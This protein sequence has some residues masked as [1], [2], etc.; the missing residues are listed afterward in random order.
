MVNMKRKL[1]KQGGSA[2]TITLPFK[3]TKQFGLEAGDELDVEEKENKLIVSTFSDI[4]GEKKDIDLTEQSSMIKRIL[5]SLYK[6]GYDE[7]HVQFDNLQQFELAQEVVREEFIGFEIVEQRKKSITVK[8]ISK[9]EYSEFDTMLRRMFMII[10]LMGEESLEAAK[11]KDKEQLK[12]IT[13]R[14][15]DVNKIADY[16]RRIINKKGLML[17][18]RPAPLYYIVEELEKIGDFYRDLCRHFENNG[19]DKDIEALYGD[20]NSFYSD[21]YDMFLKFDLKS[22]DTFGKKRET[23]KK[24]VDSLW[25]KTSVDKHALHYLGGLLNSLFD[26]NGPL[27]AVKL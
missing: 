24:K 27:M 12:M 2:L 8:R 13:L 26:M 18:S 16:C 9:V 20:I 11:A 1:V 23:L 6:A 17:Q 21:F 3:W 4:E 19:L 22:M 10:K 14:D 5:G 25:N 7:F 15:K